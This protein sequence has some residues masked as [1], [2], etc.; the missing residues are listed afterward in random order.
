[1]DCIGPAVA[2]VNFRTLSG[3][4]TE[5]VDAS[6][7][8]NFDVESV[9]LSPVPLPPALPLFGSAVLALAGLATWKR[10]KVSPR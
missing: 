5:F 9:S 8:I 2:A 1:M 4:Q 3:V 7:T 6:E 10:G